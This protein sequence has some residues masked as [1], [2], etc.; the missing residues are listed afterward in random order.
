[1]LD[2]AELAQAIA[3]RP[4]TDDA[5]AAYESVMLPRSNDQAATTADLLAA[6][7]PDTDSTE[8]VFPDVLG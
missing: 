3:D 7:M 4:R 2:G 6:L 8:P 5:V 1:M